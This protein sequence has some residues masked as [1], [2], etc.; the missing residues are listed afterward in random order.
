MLTID[1]T[2]RM[3]LDALHDFKQKNEAA[4]E[5]PRGNSAMGSPDHR[6]NLWA[7]GTP[8]ANAGRLCRY[9]LAKTIP[10]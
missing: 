5:L 1:A 7:S 6:R 3:V 9:F 2:D 8:S 10:C 4:P